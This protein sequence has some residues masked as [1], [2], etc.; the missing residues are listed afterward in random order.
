MNEEQLRGG[1]RAWESCEEGIPEEE[2]REREEEQQDG[3]NKEL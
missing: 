2:E 3:L 1:E